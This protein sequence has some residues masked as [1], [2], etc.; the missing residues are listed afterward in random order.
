MTADSMIATILRQAPADHRASI[1]AWRQ[2]S[3]ILAQRGNQLGDEDIRRSL[4]ALAVLRPRVPE[5]VRRDCARAIA[6]HGRFAPL[7]AFYAN[8]VPAVAAIMLRS[9]Q[10]SEADWLAMLPAG[11]YLVVHL[12]EA[13]S[14]TPML[15]ARRFT[16]N[17][18]LV[19]IAI[20][21]WYWMWGVMGAFLAV[22]MLAA[23]KLVCDRVG[24]L[25]AIG[26]FI[27]GDPKD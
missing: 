8:D 6:K 10:L 9:A 22:P 4:H 24:P 15:L 1:A 12:I 14:V 13:D 21:F 7:V 2:L 5:G 20:V 23:F 26:H 16:I 17:P 19:I 27:G 18:V 11:I 3:D 25:A